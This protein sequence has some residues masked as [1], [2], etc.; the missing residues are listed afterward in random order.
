[1]ALAFPSEWNYLKIMLIFSDKR[2]ERC[3]VNKQ[4]LRP[5]QKGHSANTKYIPFTLVFVNGVWLILLQ[6]VQ[7]L[8]EHL[9]PHF[10]EKP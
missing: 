5:K 10:A 7:N 2:Q 3:I 4:E 6:R 1:M 9:S 8:V